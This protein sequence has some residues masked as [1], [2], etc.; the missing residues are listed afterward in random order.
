MGHFGNWEWAGNSFSLTR[1]HQLYVI[2]HPLRN[3]YFNRLII[4]MRTRFGTKL[5]PMKETLREMLQSRSLAPGATAFISDQTPH[6]EHAYWT[7]F[8]NQDTPVFLG[9]EKFAQKLGYPVVY[10]SV[11]RIKRGYY[12]ID[13]ELLFE[14]PKRTAPTEITERHTRR[15]E[16]DIRSLPYTWLWSHRRWK[17][18]RPNAA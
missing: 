12:E 1:R 16:Q 4:G 11:R 8:M 18:K 9:A 17:H 15:L 7:T 6:P 5:I 13:A 3:P 14:D 2:Y 10:V